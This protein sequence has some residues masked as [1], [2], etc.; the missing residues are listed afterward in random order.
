MRSL[1]II[2]L[3]I[4]LS[5]CGIVTKT[6]DTELS[7]PGGVID[8][9]A[10][11]LLVANSPSMRVV[12]GYAVT[13]SLSAIA[14]EANLDS[15]GREAAASQVRVALKALKKA[16]ECASKGVPDN[17]VYFDSKML[18][19]NQAIYRLALTALPVEEV[20][21]LLDSPLNAANAIDALLDFGKRAIKSGLRVFAVVRDISELYYH[22]YS[23]ALKKTS[24]E[25]T[26]NERVQMSGL[27]KKAYISTRVGFSAVRLDGKGVEKPVIGVNLRE[28]MKLLST[29]EKFIRLS[30]G[31][32]VP[33][34]ILTAIGEEAVANC[35]K[36]ASD[37][38]TKKLCAD[39]A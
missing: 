33:N 39:T 6:I 22:V 5:G 13:T 20:K 18:D 25:F 38:D 2:F 9:A 26:D 4:S 15:A 14:L 37:E 36:L 7:N 34:D 23:S 28:L 11:K 1:C 16:S 29:D 3:S 30:I 8:V 10:D 19:V 27:L 32:K 12:R 21:Q 17:C 35:E 24:T 31:L